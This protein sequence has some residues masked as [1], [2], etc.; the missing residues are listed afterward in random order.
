MGLL[1]GLTLLAAEPSGLAT[2]RASR[3][4]PG[5]PGLAR[6]KRAAASEKLFAVAG[7]RDLVELVP[8]EVPDRLNAALSVERAVAELAGFE[9]A[10][11]GLLPGRVRDESG[12]AWSVP[13]LGVPHSRTCGLSR[14]ALKDQSG[15]ALCVSSI[16]TRSAVP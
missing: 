1:V 6:A 3:A 9:I 11:V 12:R 5:N 14:T 4:H 16:S 10:R 8:E 7:I 13:L 15:F 2:P